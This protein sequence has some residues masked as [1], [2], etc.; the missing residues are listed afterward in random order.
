MRRMTRQDMTRYDEEQAERAHSRPK[1]RE[2]YR[3]E[4]PEGADR[5]YQE[6]VERG[7]TDGGS[8]REWYVLLPPEGDEENA[9]VTDH[10]YPEAA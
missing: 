1:G 3:G 4:N 7:W 9:V 8:N 2:I 5:R 10:D 6:L